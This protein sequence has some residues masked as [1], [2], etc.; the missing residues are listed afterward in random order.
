[1]SDTDVEDEHVD[2]EFDSYI[3]FSLLDV[4]V[5]RGNNNDEAS[6]SQSATA[7]LPPSEDPQLIH[8]NERD[9][10]DLPL[11]LRMESED[12]AGL[13]R[14]D[15]DSPPSPVPEPI[16]DRPRQF[17]LTQPTNLTNEYHWLDE[18][19]EFRYQCD[20]VCHIGPPHCAE[21]NFTHNGPLFNGRNGGYRNG[22]GRL[23]RPWFRRGCQEWAFNYCIDEDGTRFHYCTRCAPT[24][25]YTRYDW[26]HGGTRPLRFCKCFCRGCED[27]HA[28]PRNRNGGARSRDDWW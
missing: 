3:K 17:R 12:P 21:R 16:P 7:V 22:A 19:E 26:Y 11:R 18:E 13:A 28:M 24:G 4:P 20:C 6:S 15:Y 23:R 5:V 9:Y 2:E 1:M 25:P 14:G 8:I 10:D 27:Y